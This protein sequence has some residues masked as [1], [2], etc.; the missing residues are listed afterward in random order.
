[1]TMQSEAEYYSQFEQPAKNFLALSDETLAMIE[2]VRVQIIDAAS[3]EDM[4]MALEAVNSVLLDMK[5]IG[6]TARLRS[7]FSMVVA[8][9]LHADGERLV[10]LP[11]PEIVSDEEF[12]GVFMGCDIAPLSAGGIPELVYRLELP[13]TTDALELRTVVA[14]ADDAEL[15]VEVEPLGVDEDNEAHYDE[16]VA[17]LN[18]I[19]DKEVGEIVQRLLEA[20]ELHEGDVNAKLLRD[21]G[22]LATEMLAHE[23]PQHSPEV[24]DALMTVIAELIEDNSTVYDLHGYSLT[25]D[26]SSDQKRPGLFAEMTMRTPI[27][28]C[29]TV[30]NY[31]YFPGD[32][33]GQD[34]SLTKQEGLQPTFVAYDEDGVE[35]LFPLKWLMGFHTTYYSPKEGSCQES[36]GRFKQENKALFKIRPKK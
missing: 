30:T 9:K 18:R 8:Q 4:T 34:A 7:D 28:G 11:Q 36:L 12:E 25:R 32:L 5:V 6:R 3:V 13:L 31:E 2:A 21:I 35:H 15:Q 23:E 29:R 20:I 10:S 26:T 19:E 27:F 17:V 24:R 14:S 22:I 1:M 33:E 16:A